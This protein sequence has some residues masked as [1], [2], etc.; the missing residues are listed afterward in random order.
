MS[1]IGISKA[2][3]DHARDQ[4]RHVQDRIAQA[5]EDLF[6]LAG[7]VVAAAGELPNGAEDIGEEELDDANQRYT[8]AAVLRVGASLAS[9][10]IYARNV[11]DVHDEATLNATK[12]AT[13]KAPVSQ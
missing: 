5:M 7:H 12:P 1:T 13:A 9:A 10:R 6:L 8:V 11:Q 2:A 3:L 4:G